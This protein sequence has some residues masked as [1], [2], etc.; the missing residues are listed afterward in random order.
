MKYNLPFSS[1][2]EI[3]EVEKF[4]DYGW[5]V[6][7]AYTLTKNNVTISGVATTFD[8]VDDLEK[9]ALCLMG[10]LLDTNVYPE[11]DE[12][13][14]DY[15]QAAMD[16]LKSPKKEQLDSIWSDIE[17]GDFAEFYSLEQVGDEY[18]VDWLGI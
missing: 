15:T 16:F 5:R 4:W 11:D 1:V 2:L 7:L 12:F 13:F 18:T 10:A 8:G 6:K 14:S 3:N 17:N 9:F